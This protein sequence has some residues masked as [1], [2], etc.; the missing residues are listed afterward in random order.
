MP[1]S[2]EYT[3]IDHGALS[4]Y[5]FLDE[6]ISAMVA[7]L[8]GFKELRQNEK[9]QN[10]V[11]AEYD[12]L[13]DRTVWGEHLVKEYDD[14]ISEAQKKGEEVH[15]GRTFGTCAEKDFEMEDEQM[16]KYKGDFASIAG[17]RKSRTLGESERHPNISRAIQ[18]QCQQESPVS[19]VVSYRDTT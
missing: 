13:R 10:S 19:A 9:V 4:H 2:G 1:A 3:I 8:V 15:F 11:K 14:V 16:R 18:H 7:R 6:H 12:G 17:P 5:P